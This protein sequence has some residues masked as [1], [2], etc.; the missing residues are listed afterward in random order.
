LTSE[1]ISPSRPKSAEVVSGEILV[2]VVELAD[3]EEGPHLEERPFLLK[4]L[5]QMLWSV[6]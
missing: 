5:L 3:K 2:A 1:E 6:A 4:M